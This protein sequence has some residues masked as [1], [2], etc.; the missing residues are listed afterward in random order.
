MI[1]EPGVHNKKKVV[2]GIGCGSNGYFVY[3]IEPPVFEISSTPLLLLLKM[4]ARVSMKLNLAKISPA[5]NN[6]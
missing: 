5:P 2:Y 6:A 4:R 1:R 3:N